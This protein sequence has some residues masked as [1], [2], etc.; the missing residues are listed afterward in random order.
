MKYSLVIKGNMRLKKETE[1]KTKQKIMHP[2]KTINS[3]C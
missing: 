1:L 2:V 3:K